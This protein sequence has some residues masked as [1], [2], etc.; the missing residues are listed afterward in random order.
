MNYKIRFP[1]DSLKKKFDKKVGNAPR[2]IQEKVSQSI[3]DLE[4]KPRPEGEPKIKPPIPVAL[5]VAQYRKRIGDC[6]IL[7]DIDDKNKTVWILAF[8]G[9][10]EKHIEADNALRNYRQH[11]ENQKRV[12]LIF[13]IEYENKKSVLLSLALKQN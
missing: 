9:R 6:G 2:Y 3:E 13:E 10:N 7:Y 5:Y 11:L 1:T 8:R 4:K 12:G